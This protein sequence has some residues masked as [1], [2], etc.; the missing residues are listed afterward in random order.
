[1]D[2]TAHRAKSNRTAFQGGS[3]ELGHRLTI[4][5][6]DDLF[7]LLN[8]TKQFGEMIFRVGD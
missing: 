3:N 1:M 5:G 4:P 6:D 2:L 8:R 7:T